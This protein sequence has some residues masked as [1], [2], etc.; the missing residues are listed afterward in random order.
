MK[1]ILALLSVVSSS[2]FSSVASAHALHDSGASFFAGV[3]HPLLGIDHVLAMIAIG[4]WG[5]QMLTR[6]AWRMPAAVAV[7]MAAGALL[8][9]S[10]VAAPVLEWF[11][12][13]SVCALGLLVVCKQHVRMLYAY[14]VIACFAFV[15]GAA[16]AVEQPA[17]FS[18]FAYLAGVLLASTAL[19]VGGAAIASLLKHNARLVG[20]PM[21]AAGVWLIAVS[22]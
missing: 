19:Q 6:R 17:E 20:L 8:A 15:H 7:A 14:A 4:M 9:P 2:S 18:T 22:A 3:V 16:H 10:I 21:I 13:A 12:I 5:C 11:I 1:K